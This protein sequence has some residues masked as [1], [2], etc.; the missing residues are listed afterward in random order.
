MNIG[1]L[2]R[3]VTIQNFTSTQDSYGQAVQTWADWKTVYGT[4]TFETGNEREEE[5]RRTATTIV[6]FTFRSLDIVGIT[7]DYRISYGGNLYDILDI[8]DYGRSNYTT[9][10]AEK[11]Y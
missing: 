2:D 5:E 6:K 3:V 9:I 4:I 10:K 8:L 11:K 7:P 1:R